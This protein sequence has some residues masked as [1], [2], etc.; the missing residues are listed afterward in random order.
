MLSWVTY[1]K[2]VYFICVY[3]YKVTT[4]CCT[5]SSSI[6]NGVKLSGVSQCF[7]FCFVWICIPIQRSWRP[8]AKCVVVGIEIKMCRALFHQRGQLYS[9]AYS[10]MSDVWYA[11]LVMILIMIAII[12]IIMNNN[13]NTTQQNKNKEKAEVK[14]LCRASRLNDDGEG[15]NDY[16]NHSKNSSNSRGSSITKKKKKILQ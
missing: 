6:L 4:G 16:T 13:N 12:R 1:S 3:L 9:N 2:H 10:C 7:C 8:L 15:D 11:V 14:V 5:Y